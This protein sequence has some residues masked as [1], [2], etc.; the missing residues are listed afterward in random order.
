MLHAF[1]A[2]QLLPRLAAFR[3][4]LR[5]A[6]AYK[7]GVSVTE[8]FST[9]LVCGTATVCW[10]T[11]FLPTRT[12]THRMVPQTQLGT[13]LIMSATSVIESTTLFKH[14][15]ST[16]TH[17]LIARSCII[18]RTA[19]ATVN[20]AA[21]HRFSIILRARVVTL[22]DLKRCRNT[23]TISSRDNR[24]SLASFECTTAWQERICKYVTSFLWYP[25]ARSVRTQSAS[26]TS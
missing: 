26:S 23:F 16:W 9:P 14:W 25:Y 6:H 10:Q 18:A 19:A 20:L 8:L 5:P 2:R 1:F 24:S 12:M 17:R 21:W 22:C 7:P 13:V 15:I 4:T 11:S 3:T